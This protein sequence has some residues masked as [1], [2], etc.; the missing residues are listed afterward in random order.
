MSR[1]QSCARKEADELV[2]SRAEDGHDRW[3]EEGVG[4][5]EERKRGKTKKMHYKKKNEMNERVKFKR[6]GYKMR[7]V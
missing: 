7:R 2:R 6:S 5:A 4:R 3:T 1:R